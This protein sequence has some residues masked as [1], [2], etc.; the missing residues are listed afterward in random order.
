MTRIAINGFEIIA[1]ISSKTNKPY[2][3]SKIHTLIPLQ[4]SDNAKGFVGSEYDCPAHVLDKIRNMQLPFEADV[5]IQ[6]VMSF[7]KRQQQ[8][9]SITPVKRAA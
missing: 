1:G 7:G 5:E 2:D 4:P 6:D 9:M 8:I 3:M